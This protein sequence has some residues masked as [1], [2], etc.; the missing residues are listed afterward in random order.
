MKRKNDTN[1]AL[2]TLK[3]SI[4]DHVKKLAKEQANILFSGNVSAY[5]SHLILSNAEKA[6]SAITVG[7]N[8]TAVAAGNSRVDSRIKK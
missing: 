5:I 7:N 4:S 3:L 2:N 8:A 1:Q 6:Q